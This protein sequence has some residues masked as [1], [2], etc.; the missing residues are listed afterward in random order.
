M[1]ETEGVSY[2]ATLVTTHPRNINALS[3][4]R[5]VYRYGS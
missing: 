5:W 2:E 1:Q 4:K 3:E